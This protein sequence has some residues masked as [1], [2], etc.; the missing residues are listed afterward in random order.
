MKVSGKVLDKKAQPIS[1]ANIMLLE[2]GKPSKLGTFT[3]L[4]GY[5][6]LENDLI[7]EDSIIEISYAGLP[8]KELKP[9]DLQETTITL[10]ESAII[11]PI[12]NFD[13]P[14]KVVEV[15][16]AKIAVKK[17]KNNF[18]QHLLSHREK[19]AVV[20]GLLG[21]IILVKSFKK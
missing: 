17:A 19:Y 14:K 8:K 18:N 4:D 6:C 2:K 10:D 12:L 20:V 3:N 15:E 1:C 5:F 9:S 21:I 13:L 16:K 11:T 7:K